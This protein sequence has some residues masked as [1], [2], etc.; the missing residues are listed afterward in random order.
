[1]PKILVTGKTGQ[2]GSELRWWTQQGNLLFPESDFLF[3]GRE[4]LPLQLGSQLEE[5][6]ETN[7]ITHIIHAAAYTA[8]DKAE[9]ESEQAVLL[10]ALIP[11][12]LAKISQKQN[13]RLIHISTDF[14]FDG[15]SS[16]PY[17]EDRPKNPLSVYGLSKSEGEDLVL[18]AYPD[19]TIL[20]T[21]WVY[22]KFGNNFVK[23]ILRLAEQR[24]K[25]T[26]IY[27]QIGTPTWARDLARICLQ[28]LTTPAP[29]IYHYSNE[30]VASWYDFAQEIVE[31]SRS[32]CEVLPILATE[33]PLPAKRPSFSVLHKGKIKSELG[34]RI[35]HWKQSLQKMLSDL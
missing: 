5:W 23:T 21:S 10:N 27:D 33:Y 26:I 3:V 25:L 9:T 34:I 24:D 14:V 1:M 29:G 11:Q 12:E 7:K 19:A 16:T 32:T 13:I 30:G 22:S 18:N 6:I 2:L 4:E 8:V 17:T 31:W 15:T 28:L 35:P 20:R